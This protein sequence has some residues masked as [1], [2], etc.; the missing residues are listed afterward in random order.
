MYYRIVCNQLSYIPVRGNDLKLKWVPVVDGNL[1]GATQAIFY[2]SCRAPRIRNRRAYF[3]FTARGWKKSNDFM[4][5][6]LRQ[7]GVAYQVKTIKRVPKSA[8]IYRDAD[9]V[10]VL[11][12]S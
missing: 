3:W 11:G 7:A 8:I 9:Q 5:Q 2:F 4:I 1:G 6:Q 12:L 10:A